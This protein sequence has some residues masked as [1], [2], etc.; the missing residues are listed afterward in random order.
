[1]VRFARLELK[2]TRLFDMPSI[3]NLL[4]SDASGGRIIISIQSPP[5]AKGDRHPFECLQFSVTRL[6]NVK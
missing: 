5:W 4:L 3:P 1:M 2:Q 6:N